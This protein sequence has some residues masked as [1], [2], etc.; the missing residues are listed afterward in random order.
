MGAQE[1]HIQLGCY[2]DKIMASIN[3]NTPY[4]LVIFGKSRVG[5]NKQK[6]KKSKKETALFDKV[7][8]INHL[9]S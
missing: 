4:T 1:M 6:I 2:V 8:K 3:S 7:A 9:L 5:E